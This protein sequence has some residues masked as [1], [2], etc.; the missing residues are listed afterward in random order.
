M[1]KVSKEAMDWATEQI[2]AGVL[3]GAI[4]RNPDGSPKTLADLRREVE[5][6]RRSANT[7]MS[8]D[9]MERDPRKLPKAGDIVRSTVYKNGRERHV[10]SALGDIIQYVAVSPTNRRTMQCRLRPWQE[11]CETAKVEVVKFRA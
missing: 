4:A 3:D 1:K 10:V 2:N 8:E 11:W 5:E 6:R 9:K 7:A